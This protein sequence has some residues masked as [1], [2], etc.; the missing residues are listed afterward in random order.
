MTEKVRVTNLEKHASFLLPLILLFTDYIA[1]ISAEELAYR[2]RYLVVYNSWELNLSWINFW[3]VFPFLFLIFLH[4]EGLYVARRQFWQTVKSVFHG[5]CYAILAIIFE[6]YVARTAASTS[7]LFIMLFGIFSFIFIVL[8]RFAVKN[9][10]AKKQLLQLPILVVGAGKTAEIFERGVADDEGLNYRIIGLLEDNEIISERLRKYPVLGG[11]DDV[12]KVIKATAV[13]HVIL[14]APGLDPLKQGELI[15]RAQPLVKNIAIIPN[16]IGMPMG[17]L[18][19]ESFFNEKLMMLKVKNNLARP[20]NILIKTIFDYTL[21]LFGTIAI[22]PILVAIAIWIYKDSPGPILFKHI[23]VGK[24]G[25]AFPCYKFRTMCVDA[26]VKLKELLETDPM[27][28]EEWERD[29]KLKND[30]RITKSGAFL[31]RTSLDELPQIFNVLKGEM[32]LV[33]PRPV[34]DEELPRYGNFLREYL[35]VKPGITGYWQVNGRSDTTYEERVAMDT[36]YVQNWSIWLDLMLLWRTF[37][38]VAKQEG[39]Y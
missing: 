22:S 35:A 17:G 13:Q 30:P 11:F 32:S 37:K 5:C 24:N 26:D 25:K 34:I 7:R 23:R 33:G 12:E 3:I 4:T 9:F 18:E 19:V 8:F 16:L 14:A 15:Y 6:M 31:R 10:L 28:R 36:W 21:T 20:W 29:F 38:S 2:M 27:A 1:V 39:A